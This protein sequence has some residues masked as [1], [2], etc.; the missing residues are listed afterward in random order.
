VPL[1]PSA[2]AQAELRAA[3]EA[4]RAVSAAVAS[5]TGSSEVDGS[6]DGSVPDWKLREFEGLK[7]AVASLW[8]QLEVPAEDVTAFLSECDLLAPYR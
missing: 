5:V 6:P 7:T 4:A 2:A 1:S 3:N 8:E